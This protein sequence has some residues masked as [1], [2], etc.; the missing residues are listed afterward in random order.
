MRNNSVLII[1]ITLLIGGLF[2]SACQSPSAKEEE[3]VENAQDTKQEL[4]VVKQDAKAQEQLQNEISAEDWKIF[5]LE[6]EQK[7]RENDTRIAELKVKMRKSGKLL[8]PLFDK[9]IE[10]LE[11]KNK[12]LKAKIIAYDKTQSNWE[13]FKREFKHD[14]DELGE[15]MKDLTIDN[16]K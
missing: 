3:A 2:L 15:A 8:D 12:V 16:K 13:E 5:K 1:A 4:E 6:S 7:I 14:M 10:N 9:K 11:Q